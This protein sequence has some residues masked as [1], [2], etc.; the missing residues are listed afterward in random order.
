[1]PSAKSHP[2]S[3]QNPDCMSNLC[4]RELFITACGLQNHRGIAHHELYPN[5][6]ICDDFGT[7]E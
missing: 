6:A 7:W 5:K 3:L 2:A 1:M 4:N